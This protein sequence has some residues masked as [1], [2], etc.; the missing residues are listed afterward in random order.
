MNTHQKRNRKVLITEKTEYYQFEGVYINEACKWQARKENTK[1][2]QTGVWNDNQDSVVPR[3]PSSKTARAITCIQC[4]CEIHLQR[5]LIARNRKPWYKLFQWNYKGTTKADAVWGV[6]GRDPW[7][8][9]MRE[10]PMCP[11][12]LFR[13]PLGR[14]TPLIGGFATIR[15]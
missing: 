7:P 8:Q 15:S 6:N 5:D 12:S 1:K 4:C 9:V 10:S 14:V 2:E 11:H 13:C 3:G